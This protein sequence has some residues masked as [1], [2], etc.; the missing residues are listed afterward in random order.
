MQQIDTDW[1]KVHL[2]I[3]SFKA[4]LAAKTTELASKV[5]DNVDLLN[6]IDALETAQATLQ[7]N[8]TAALAKVASDQTAQE[9]HDEAATDD[10]IP[11]VIVP[12]VVVPPVDPTPVEPVTPVAD[13][14]GDT[15]LKS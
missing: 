13:D 5:Q 6:E 7:A 2:E 9:I 8:L 15:A 4:K 1:A 10:S 11:P 14:T 12:P 3:A